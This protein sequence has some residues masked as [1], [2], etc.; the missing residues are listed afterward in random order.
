M[1]ERL[2]VRYVRNEG[3]ILNFRLFFRMEWVRILY[4]ITL[5]CNADG[6]A[7]YRNTGDKYEG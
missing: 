5:F 4:R 1:E 3:F 6:A 7:R 2:A